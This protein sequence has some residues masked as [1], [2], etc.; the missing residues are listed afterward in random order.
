M[1][2]PNSVGESYI[3]Y[4]KLEK[5]FSAHTVKAYAHDLDILQD[6]IAKK[7]IDYQ[8]ITLENLQD[9]IKTNIEEGIRKERSI[10]RM[11]SSLNTFFKFC[12]MEKAIEYNP[13]ELLEAPKL[14]LYLPDVLSIEE[15]DRMLANIDL[16]QKEGHRNVA[17]IE[18]LYGSGVRASELINIRLSDTYFQEK[19]MRI[20][21]K[22]NKQRL[23]P[24]SD[25]MIKA[26]NFWFK[27]RNLMKIQ[28]K[29]EDFLFLNRRGSQLTRQMIYEIIKNAA[30]KAE[31]SKTISP[32]TLRHSFATHLLEGGANLRAIQQMLGHSSITTTEIYTHINMDFLRAEIIM[33]HPRNKLLQ[34]C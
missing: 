14:P 34:G 11:E 6:Y 1:L 23:V 16:S 17:I 15:I 5:A 21:G 28:P 10:A 29:Q 20:I 18:T 19:Y 4:L 30:Q 25:N 13:A 3:A 27:D 8:K 33:K 12:V 32:H 31:I 9:F 24:I 26:I 22:G 7:E 2:F